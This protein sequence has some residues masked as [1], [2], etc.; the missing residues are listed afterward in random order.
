[1]LTYVIVIVDDNIKSIEHRNVGADRFCVRQWIR[2]FYNAVFFFWFGNNGTDA[3]IAILLPTL[4]RLF[5]LE[6]WTGA[7]RIFAVKA[8]Y[9]NDYSFVIAQCE[10]RR[11][12]G[13]H[14]NRAVLSVHAI[15]T[16]VR[17]F[18]AAGSTL[19]KKGGSVKTLRSFIHSLVFSPKTGL[20][21]TRNQSGDRYGSG[22]L[23]PGQVLR[24]MLPLLFPAFRRSHILRQVPLRPTTRETSSS[25]RWN[26]SWTRNVPTNFV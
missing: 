13:M 12:F 18:E 3:D 24:G 19:K 5:A 6:P 23:H 11:E 1:M 22:T 26:S 7:Q 8:F 10:F 9:K 2:P 14:R 21:G 25:G 15:K 17:N 20:A 16:W 4:K